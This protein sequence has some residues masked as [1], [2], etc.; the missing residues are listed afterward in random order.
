MEITSKFA[1]DAVLPKNNAVVGGF[2]KTSVFGKS[3]SDLREKAGFKP[4][5][6]KP[7]LKLT[8]FWKRLVVINYVSMK[9]LL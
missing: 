2:P 7:F 6:P 1:A 5:F 3:S 9:E 8:E 4:L